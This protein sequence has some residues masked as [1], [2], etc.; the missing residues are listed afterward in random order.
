[1][2]LKRSPGGSIFPYYYKNGELFGAHFGSFFDNEKALLARMKAE[3]EFFLNENKQLPYWVD[4]YESRL[5]DKVLLEFCHSISHMQNIITRLAIVGCSF[6][7]RFRLRRL[8][9]KKGLTFPM[10]IRFYSD[11]EVAK[12]WLI[13]E[14]Y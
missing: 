14:K 5:S 11:P 12:S 4:F 13:G 6:R 2:A 1:M 8:F 7:D 9:K 10:P 3:E